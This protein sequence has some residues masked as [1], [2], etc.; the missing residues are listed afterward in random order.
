MESPKSVLLSL[1]WVLVFVGHA[2]GASQVSARLDYSR[3]L[4]IEGGDTVTNDLYLLSPTW[5]T[6]L[7]VTGGDPTTAPR[8]EFQST[9]TFTELWPAPTRIDPGPTYVW[10]YPD[11]TLPPGGQPLFLDAHEVPILERPGLTA[12]RA[13]DTPLLTS[14]S[15]AQTVDFT[16]RFDEPLPD[17]VDNVHVSVGT[18]GFD[19]RMIEEVVT[20]QNTVPG[21]S[22]GSSEWGNASWNATSG[23]ITVGAEVHFQA[24]ILCARKPGYEGQTIYHKPRTTVLYSDSDNLP[25]HT[26]TWTAITHPSGETATYHLNETVAWDRTITASRQDVDFETV[27]RVVDNSGLQVDGVELTFGKI[28]DGDGNFVH[29]AFGTNVAG[30]NAVAGTLTTPTGRVWSLTVDEQSEDPAMYLDVESPQ[31]SDFA[32]LGFVAGDYV[33]ECQGGTG[34][35]VTVTI[36][37]PLTTP[38]QVPDITHPIHGAADVPTTETFTW[39]PVTDPA[40]EGLYVEVS[41]EDPSWEHGR[42]LPADSTSW[43]TPSMPAMA[44]VEAFLAFADLIENTTPDGIET[45]VI[46]YCAQNIDFGTI[47]A[48][49][50][51]DLDGDVDDDDLSLLLANWGQDVTSR[52]D[53]GWGAGEFTAA[54]PV[55]DDDLSLLLA[56]W[57]G[58]G[59]IGVPEPGATAV[60]LAAA[61]SVFRR[62]HG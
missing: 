18:L 23:A 59:S 35:T 56:N 32:D 60:L 40:V 33:I 27:S 58:A 46:G 43:E 42:E 54:A 6:T 16:V 57:T 1:V 39:A 11:K 26:G 45:R 14:D 31:F 37:T 20:L 34:Q 49:G 53:D 47:P 12:T 61:M 22:S 62:R 19:Q 44:D 30:K 15:V 21:W 28:C 5:Q 10:D 25:G 4:R 41:C 9:R 29:Y 55:N 51:A 38:T 52:P 3:R 2:M 50:D 13:V 8:M 36:N 24:R 7:S 48:P 17:G